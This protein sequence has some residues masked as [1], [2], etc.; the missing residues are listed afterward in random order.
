MISILLCFDIQGNNRIP[1]LRES[2]VS[3]R[4]GATYEKENDENAE[5]TV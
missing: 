2:C 3:H 4:N 1:D 5:Y